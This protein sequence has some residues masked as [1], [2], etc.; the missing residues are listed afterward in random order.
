MD[1][2]IVIPERIQDD[3]FDMIKRYIY[4]VRIGSSPYFS[5]DR[6]NSYKIGYSNNLKA[7]IDNLAY[8]HQSPVTLIAYGISKN[9]IKSETYLHKLFSGCR[10]R[11]E[12][13]DF[14]EELI[15]KF[16][17]EMNVVCDCVKDMR[18]ETKGWSES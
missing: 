10:R 8:I 4:L 16:I 11:G 6:F 7:R 14:T 1:A 13:F 2:L 3:S 12:Y 9:H 18:E 17:I 15:S 5:D